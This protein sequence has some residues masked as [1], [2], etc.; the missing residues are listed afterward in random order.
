M[1]NILIVEDDVRICEIIKDYLVR[2]GHNCFITNTGLDILNIFHDSNPH[3][4][5][6][7]LMLPHFDGYT[8]CKLVRTISDV[9]IIILTAK[10]EEY[11]KLKGYELGADDYITKPFSPKVLCAKVKVLLKRASDYESEESVSIG[12]I[13]INLSSRTVIVNGEHV[14]LTYK[15]F[16]LLH[17]LMEN[18]NRVFTREHLLNRVWDYE[19]EGNTRTVDTHI[20]TLRQKLG[21]EGKHIVTMIR[22]GYKFEV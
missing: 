2:D 3:L 21:D 10:S 15:E 9:P 12:N 22:S 14:E 8:I 6:L 20:K 17:L 13:N 16:E 1:A 19:Y 11:D 4:I 7:D 5:I 18:P